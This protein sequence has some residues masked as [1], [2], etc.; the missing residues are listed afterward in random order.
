AATRLE[1]ARDS[2]PVS[3]Q[4]EVTTV[5]CG[6]SRRS[7]GGASRGGSRGGGGQWPAQPSAS[8]LAA[9]AWDC[10]AAAFSLAGAP[11][12]AVASYFL[13]VGAGSVDSCSTAAPDSRSL[14]NAARCGSSWTASATRRRRRWAI[15]SAYGIPGC[16]CPTPPR[17][18]TLSS[19][20]ASRGPT[21]SR[22]LGDDPTLPRFLARLH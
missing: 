17:W 4:A 12:A 20:T 21:S 13:T 8:T 5:S 15:I 1:P 11:C 7:P 14:A 22:A 16:A 9:D 19:T 6:F 18:A 3:G 10:E 2:A